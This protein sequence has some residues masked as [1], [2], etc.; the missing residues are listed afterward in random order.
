MISL[1]FGAAPLHLRKEAKEENLENREQGKDEKDE[2]EEKK[3]EDQ[4]RD[5]QLMKQEEDLGS[6]LGI[7]NVG[8]HNISGPN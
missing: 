7:P 4:E 5:D 6:C 1:S 8:R 2:E 3:E